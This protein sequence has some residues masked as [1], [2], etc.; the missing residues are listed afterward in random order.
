M[1]WQGGGL[2]KLASNALAV[3]VSLTLVVAFAPS[4]AGVAYAATGDSSDD[5]V[6]SAGTYTVSVTE[7][8][9]YGYLYF[10]PE[11]TALYTAA[12]SAST[13]AVYMSIQSYYYDDD[14]EDYYWGS[15]VYAYSSSEGASA[16]AK[17]L[18]VAGESYRIRVA[19]YDDEE[20]DLASTTGDITVV[21]EQS[22][23]SVTAALTAGKSQT[24]TIESAGEYLAYSFTAPASATYRFCATGD[25]DTYGY[26]C[27]F[28]WNLL[29]YDDDSGDSAN[30][31][32]AYALTAGETY[33]FVVR[34][35]DS[36]DTGSFTVA[37][38]QP[39]SIE[40]ATVTLSA[41]SYEFTGNSITPEVTV[42]LDGTVLEE[43]VDYYTSYSNNTLPGTA[44]VYVYGYDGSELTASFTITEP[45]VATAVCAGKTYSTD[46][47]TEGGYAC[48][49]ITPSSSATYTF[50]TTGDY[51]TYSCLYDSSW[52]LL[53]SDD[54]DDSGVG[55]TSGF[56][57]CISYDLT[58]GKT[59]YLVYQFLSSSVTGTFDVV[60]G[61][62]DLSVAK[63]TASSCTYTG[64][65]LTPSVTVKLD[66]ATLVADTDYTVAYSNN[67]NAGTGTVTVTGAGSYS[68]TA[69]ATF[70]IAKAS[71]SLKVTKKTKTVKYKKLKKKKLTVKAIT[72]VSGAKGTLSYT[73]GAVKY[74]GKKA[75][76][77]VAKKIVVNKK[78]GK[79]TLKKGLK[80]G[81]Y[82]VKVKVKAAA[83]GNY[84][85]ASKTVTVK[86]KVK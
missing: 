66:G 25:Y 49:K 15:S 72:K 61:P 27:D 18:L 20:E 24:A 2:R 74:K 32:I 29:T 4:F 55:A 36:S 13:S 12:A 75:S 63:V 7:S 26:L 76:K 50:Y 14:D 44:T 64:K 53:A 17:F 37:V 19:F 1:E 79:I 52:D 33:Y 41:Y 38:T 62:T 45:N 35:Y 54:D 77:K 81:T 56:N 67:K 57:T 71:Q 30:T 39:T 34:M 86:I 31:A 43:D 80:K 58:A 73:K 65:A 82:T 47:N 48:Y 6:T 11:E 70:T 42:T 83:T 60:E 21:I 9:E 23:L 10:T 84:K 69:S 16:T 22:E 68:G 85:A 78:K 5:P 40:G 3:F 8:Y 28:D 59:Y 46:I 51:D